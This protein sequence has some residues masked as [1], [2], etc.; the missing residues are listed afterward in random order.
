M[1]YSDINHAL[2]MLAGLEAFSNGS[3]RSPDAVYAAT[4]LK[5]HALDAGHVEGTEGFMD[6]IKKGAK[7]VKDWIVALIK[8][9]KEYLTS[10]DRKVAETRKKVSD[11]GKQID[12]AHK[13]AKAEK[14]EGGDHAAGWKTDPKLE[15]FSKSI[16]S[17]ISDLE[18]IDGSKA[19]PVEFTA[20]TSK[21]ITEL[22]VLLKAS[23]EEKS[24]PY[25]FAEKICDIIKTI[26]AQYTSF[27]AALKKWG[28]SKDEKE[29]GSIKMGPDFHKISSELHD[30]SRR[31]TKMS[32][33][34]VKRCSAELAA[35]TGKTEK[36]E[37]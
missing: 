2:N 20:D 27:C 17:I 21:A 7:N 30:A 25:A 3:T 35:T 9:I 22:K 5:L 26:D 13:A 28:D 18:G 34:M 37:E 19:Q 23:G 24:D 31:L 32:E 29:L 15:Q 16:E 11:L 8:A 4:V 6:A 12:T 33:E 36:E 10:T 14:K 1:S